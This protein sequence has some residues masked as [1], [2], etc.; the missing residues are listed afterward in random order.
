MDG[1][2]SQ[3]P[4]EQ[5]RGRWVPLAIGAAIIVIVLAV[6]FVF[7]RNPQRPAGPAPEDPYASNLRL[8]DLGLKEAHNFAGGSITYV[9]GKV[10]NLG[11]RTVTAISVEA[12]FRNS[13]GEV[14][15]RETVPLRVL[16][17]RPGYTDV[18]S[19]AANP[20]T[21]NEEQEF[22]LAFEGISADWNRG[23]PELRII[24]VGTK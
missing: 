11:S 19:L 20:L 10:A 14:V 2:F 21:P 8:S 16:Q 7:Y 22:R 24:N 3:A 13:L 23:I 9:E 6:I 12:V 5:E 18:I 4:A 17:E 1:P 15:G